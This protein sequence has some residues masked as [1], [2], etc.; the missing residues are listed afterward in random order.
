MENQDKKVVFKEKDLISYILEFI[1][2]MLLLFI[3]LIFFICILHLMLA[4]FNIKDKSIE[5][6]SKIVCFSYSGF[7]LNTIPIIGSILGFI[8]SLFFVGT[9]LKN[10]YNIKT[11]IAIII[12]FIIIFLILFCFSFSGIF[13]YLYL[14][15]QGRF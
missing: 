4:I 11:W 8:T 15:A 9:G 6:T 13:Y 12:P 3:S 2:S 10:A 7:L 5:M 1:S 14:L